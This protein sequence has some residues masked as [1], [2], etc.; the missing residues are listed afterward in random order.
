MSRGV[1]LVAVCAA[2]VLSFPSAPRASAQTLETREVLATGDV[3]PEFG[4]LGQ[5]G[6]R[7]LGLADDGRLLVGGLTS[8]GRQGLFWANN[9]QVEPLWML[10]WGLERVAPYQEGFN[11][12]YARRF[13][14]A[15]RM[16]VICVG[17][18]VHR[19]AMEQAITS[20]G[21][22]MV[23]V[24]RALIANPHLYRH[25]RDGVDGPQ[26]DFCNACYARATAVPVDC[27][28]PTIRAQKEQMLQR[29]Q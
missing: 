29:E 19:A 20:G 6:F 10:D 21:C 3:V 27:Y 4:R 9:H 5:G 11:L 2:A 8:N 18:F 14:E 23:S 28:N 13:K 16:P 26:C 12:A 22:D 24:A 7:I 17:G 15:L 25:M 1:C